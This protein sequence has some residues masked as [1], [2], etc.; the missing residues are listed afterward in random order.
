MKI[1]WNEGYDPELAAKKIQA[2][3]K[4][5]EDGRVSFAGFEFKEFETLLF[6]MLK[7]PSEIPDREGQ[8]IVR[9]AIRIAAK[10]GKITPKAILIQ[11]SKLANSYLAL[12]FE[13][14]A[15]YTS[16]SIDSRWILP[17]SRL[18]YG[19]NIVT[20]DRKPSKKFT[21]AASQLME[22]AKTLTIGGMPKDYTYVKI[23][24]SAREIYEAA[25]LAIDTID[26]IRG[27][28]NW[29]INLKT[30]IRISMGSKPQPVNKLI[31]G[32]VHTLHYPNGNLAASVTWWYEPNYV[33]S[34]K[35]YNI[36][37]DITELTTFLEKVKSKLTKHKY[38]AIIKN[39][40]IRYTRA[41]DERNWQ[42]GF[43]RLWGV[44]ELLT[45]TE[46]ESYDV[47]IRRT[48][49]LF[50]E[51]DYH[52]QVLSQLREFRNSTVHL[53]KE[54]KEIETHLYQ[55]KRYVEALLSFHLFNDFGFR[56][57]QEAITFLN[58]PTEQKVLD[59]RIK[60]LSTAKK[61]RGY[62]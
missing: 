52:R 16:I 42:S 49:F 6:S 4:V 58:L 18:Q 32:P 48:A 56:N 30:P 28:L 1:A 11:A 44:L 22:Q 20:F 21:R 17:I 53:D 10:D 7:F 47:T 39:A 60:M 51:I 31:M 36:E 2:I 3:T 46:K 5:A 45:N 27:V 55:L 50:E 26:L 57:I 34:I 8:R 24:I 59:N 43:L 12:P 15:L 25:N 54:D 62:S 33:G 23:F 40:I 9:D 14:Y 61:F 19:K 41:L 13:R 35:T 29:R 38:S 37:K